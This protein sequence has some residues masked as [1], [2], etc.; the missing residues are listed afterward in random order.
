[1][2]KLNEHLDHLYKT[3]LIE[4]GENEALLEYA[5]KHVFTQESVYNSLL[6]SDRRHLHQLVGN[7]LEESAADDLEDRAL[8]L[9]H[10]FEMAGDQAKAL[11]YLA[12][13]AHQANQTFAN[14]EAYALY[15]RTLKLLDEA[16]HQGR[17]DTYVELEAILDRLGDR[18][19]QASTLT[20][21]QTLAELMNDDACLAVTHQRRAVY[22]D[23]ISEYQESEAAAEASLRLARQAGDS[24][25]IAHSLNLLAQASWRRFQYEDVQARAN[26]ALDALHIVGEPGTRT[27]ALLHLGRASYRLGEY[28]AAL[29][30]IQ[31]ALKLTRQTDNRTSE[32]LCYLILGWIYQRLGDYDTSEHQFQR[33]L[34]IRQ[35]IGDRYG[36]AEALSHLGW[37]AYDQTDY[38]KGLHY[39]EDALLL[40]RTIGDRENEAYALSGMGLA[41]DGMGQRELAIECYQEALLRHRAINAQTLVMFDLSRLARLALAVNDLPIA[42]SYTKEIIDWTSEYGAE[43]FWDP[44]LIHYTN[45]QVLQANKQT[46][47][48]QAILEEAHTLLQTRA[49]RISDAELRKY[50]LEKV[51]VNRLIIEAWETSRT[52]AT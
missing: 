34:E 48:A 51:A 40:S 20:I 30:Y 13:A 37:V 47:Q 50:F 14:E 18:D 10:H 27:T 43:R 45:Y 8:V 11:K 36:E 33:D 35:A 52:K 16:D 22:F 3:G 42:Y 25:L 28:E 6:R 2:N 39:C 9:A 41:Y 23:R 44:W 4:P 1:M 12:I 26:Q 38:E 46:E 15:Q 29:N 32:A 7:I 49:K 31:A 19:K 21:L 24:E 17:W 5:F